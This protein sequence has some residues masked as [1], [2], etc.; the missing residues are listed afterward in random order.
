MNLKTF[1]A[2]GTLTITR[3]RVTGYA[4]AVHDVGAAVTAVIDEEASF[5]MLEYGEIRSVML[6]ATIGGEQLKINH[7]EIG[8]EQTE[9]VSKAPDFARAAR[10][11]FVKLEDKCK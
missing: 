8:G 4:F 6:L 2:S 5:P 11:L 9:S 10:A 1:N 3:S 7:M